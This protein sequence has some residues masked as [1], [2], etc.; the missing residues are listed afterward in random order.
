M[1]G[2]NKKKIVNVVTGFVYD[3]LT[4]AC[5]DVGIRMPILIDMLKGRKQN[6]T[7]LK[8]Y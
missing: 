1:L 7:D 3:S 4:D 5:K 6:K 2:K 8:Y